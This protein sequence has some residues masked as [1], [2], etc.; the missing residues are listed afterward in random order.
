MDTGDV[1]KGEELPLQLPAGRHVCLQQA[2]PLKLI[3]V[4]CVV[5]EAVHDVAD[6]I[7]D[8][9][10]QLGQDIVPLGLGQQDVRPAEDGVHLLEPLLGLFGVE[11]KQLNRHMR[12]RCENG[13]ASGGGDGGVHRG[14]NMRSR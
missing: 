13:G 9:S 10:G 14:A 8:V 4:G 6:V 11:M 3:G 5:G 7:E 12:A 1:R 2:V